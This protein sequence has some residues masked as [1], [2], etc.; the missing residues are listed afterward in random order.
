MSGPGVMLSRSP[1]TTNRARSWMPIM[2][3]S[4]LGSETNYFRAHSRGCDYMHKSSLTPFLSAT[5]QRMPRHQV[6]RMF[7]AR[8]AANPIEPV[9][10]RRIHA[11]ID[12]D[13]V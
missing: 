10:D 12:A 8:L 9:A 13:L 4:E 6:V 7:P 3:A 5:R 2:K 11:P 1:A